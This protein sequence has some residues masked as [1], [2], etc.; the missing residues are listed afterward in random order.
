[1]DLFRSASNVCHDCGDVT[2]GSSDRIF[3][4]TTLNSC[5]IGLNWKAEA[6]GNSDLKSAFTPSLDSSIAPRLVVHHQSGDGIVLQFLPVVASASRIFAGSIVGPDRSR[7]A[8]R[9]LLAIAA[10]VRSYHGIGVSLGTPP[11]CAA[12]V[13]CESLLEVAEDAH[14]V[15]DQT[16]LLILE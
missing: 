16:V 4:A 2:T 6:S 13:D 12:S 9:W 15:H 5:Q 7:R 10:P 8:W 1:M 14:V 3:S 11:S